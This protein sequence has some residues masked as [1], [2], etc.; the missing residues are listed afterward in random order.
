MKKIKDL[1]FAE[2]RRICKGHFCHECP[3]YKPD[4]I[5]KEYRICLLTDLKRIHDQVLDEEIE[6]PKE[7]KK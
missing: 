1:T 4:V 3:L 5:L 2:F 6:I 7:E